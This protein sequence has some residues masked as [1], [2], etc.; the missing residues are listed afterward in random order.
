MKPLT[1]SVRTVAQS[2]PTKLPTSVQAAE[3]RK[4]RRRPV[5]NRQSRPVKK[6]PVVL[7]DHL[8][9]SK[10]HPVGPQ[11]HLVRSKDRPV[12]PQGHLVRSKDHPVDPQDRLV[13]PED[14]LAK[15]ERCS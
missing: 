7:K 6:H 5:R 1:F 11:G 14:H 10:D 2:S 9:R 4:T 13:S 12:G 15:T 3:Q 8:V